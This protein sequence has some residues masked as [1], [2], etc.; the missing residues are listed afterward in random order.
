MPTRSTFL[1]FYVLL[2]LQLIYGILSW[3]L[4]YVR[5]DLGPGL[6][7]GEM[8]YLPALLIAL[9]AAAAWFIDTSRAKQAKRYQLT[10]AVGH[11]RYRT[12]VLLRLAIVQ[13]ANLMALTLALSARRLDV[14]SLLAPGLLVF[15][16]FRPSV[17]Q[18]RERYG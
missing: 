11:R 9:S 15:M 13:A 4:I 12:T 14:M 18:F 5:S 8:I 3:Y 2:G 10:E 6:G 7:D 17:G 16:F 1:I